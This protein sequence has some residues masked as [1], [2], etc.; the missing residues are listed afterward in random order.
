MA[1]LSLS[2]TPAAAVALAAMLCATACI[3][4]ESVVVDQPSANVNELRTRSVRIQAGNCRVKQAEV[5]YQKCDD[6]DDADL[7]RAAELRG[8]NGAP[9]RAVSL[10]DHNLAKENFGALNAYFSRIPVGYGCAATI[11]GIFPSPT[12]V[13]EC[14]EKAKCDESS[15]PD[16]C[17][18]ECVTKHSDPDKIT[19]YDLLALDELIGAVRNSKAV[20]LWTVGYGLGDGQG[21]CKYGLANKSN[22][23]AIPYSVDGN[24][25][26]EQLGT[27]IQDPAKWAKVARKI[28]RWYNRDLVKNTKEKDATCKITKP[29]PGNPKSWKCSASLFHI[30]FGRDPNGAGGFNDASKKK[31]LE[32]YTE[33][34]K[35]MRAEFPWPANSVRIYAPSVVVDSKLLLPNSKSW[36]KDFIDHV[37]KNKLS[38]SGLS[39]EVVAENPVEARNIAAAVRKYADDRKLLD[40]DGKPISL[41]VTSLR[42]NP[43]GLPTSLF[44]PQNPDDNSEAG[45]LRK[46]RYSAYEGSFFAATK[47]L[48]QGIVKDATVGRVVRLPT[49][50]P[51]TPP[52]DVAKTAADSNL[53]WYPSDKRPPVGTAKPAAWHSFWFNYG[54]LGAGAGRYKECTPGVYGGLSCKVD[55]D[56]RV[57]QMVNNKPKAQ[58]CVS[59]KCRLPCTK[60]DGCPGA[61]DTCTDNDVC[62]TECADI[63]AEKR[64]KSIIQAMHGPDAAGISGPAKSDEKSGLVVLATRENCVDT[65][66]NLLDCVIETDSAGNLKPTFPAVT[67]GRKHVIRVLVADLN[68]DDSGKELLVHNLSVRVQDLPK[69]LGVKTV[70]YRWARMNGNRSTWCSLKPP[71][72]CS[73]V[74]PEQGVIDVA[75]DSFTITRAVAVPSLHY[76]EFLY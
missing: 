36:L 70:G 21:T 48:W 23:S 73:F 52:D 10:D 28:A 47:A 53:M 75:D 49:V 32:S 55:G 69:Q 46:A 68:V 42:L 9:L 66:G 76:F 3:D 74:F 67:Q 39:F 65:Q 6:V 63:A 29:T 51:G 62:R 30:E 41:F 61:G 71:H 72:N 31:W 60:S 19:N 34:S 27:A 14:E 59:G 33:F 25:V 38:L 7:L 5:K 12:R 57:K 35:E 18:K 24:P 56:C 44:D 8:V 22:K 1:K 50:K 16:L 58:V 45:K 2:R 37:V 17:R 64:R 13:A 11:Q 43:K 54:F 40:D 15:K 20:P 4:D 26:A